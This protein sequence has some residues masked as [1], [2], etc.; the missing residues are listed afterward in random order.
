MKSMFSSS[1][2]GMLKLPAEGRDRI[3]AAEGLDCW[4][5]LFESGLKFSH[6]YRMLSREESRGMTEDLLSVDNRGQGYFMF[7]C[8]IVPVIRSKQFGWF[9][10][11]RH[12]AGRW[13]GN[14]I[15]VH[16][17]WNLFLVMDLG[18]PSLIDH[19]QNGRLKDFPIH[20]HTTMPNHY[21]GE[22]D[23][24][25]VDPYADDPFRD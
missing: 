4:D 24:V 9:G 22:N 25:F 20:T 14:P 12:H 8:E 6:G 2:I 17:S 21:Y 5:A 7:T 19:L 11:P 15:F 23:P 1:T 16:N 3:L 13:E 18:W 10:F